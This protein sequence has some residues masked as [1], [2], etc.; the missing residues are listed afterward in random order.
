MFIGKFLRSATGGQRGDTIVEVLISITVISL[1]LGGAYATA[2]KS[3]LI[4]RASQERSNALKLAESQME[5]IKGL[6]VSN[7]SALFG[8]ASPFCIYNQTT[9][10]AASDPRCV[11]N[12][13]GGTATAEPKFSLSVTRAGNDFTVRNSW[14]NPDGKQ[15]DQLQIIYR[16]YQ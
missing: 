8:A 10:I 9:V 12:T 16:V 6:A 15:T 5:Q 4:T 2:N 7:P 11:Q 14:L 3:L 1:V 13:A